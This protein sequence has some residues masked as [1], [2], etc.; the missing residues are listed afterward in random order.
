MD[1]IIAMRG[2]EPES[3]P[4][5]LA[6]DA[7]FDAL[8]KIFAEPQP[9]TRC[10][11][12]RHRSSCTTDARD[13]SCAKKKERTYVE[14]ARRDSSVDEESCQIRK[15]K[16]VVGASSSISV[17]VER[18]TT[19]GAEIYVGTTEGDPSITIAGYGKPY[20]PTY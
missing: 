18:S 12:K 17:I 19:N 10:H 6:E 9:Q 2:I 8:L 5:E 7:A 15:R 1:T 13:D 3:V 4:I 16:M 11:A 20:L 14:A